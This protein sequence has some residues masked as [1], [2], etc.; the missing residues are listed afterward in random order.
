M[1]DEKQTCEGATTMTTTY[2]SLYKT[3]WVEVMKRVSDEDGTYIYIQE[4][5]LINGQAVSVLPFKVLNGQKFYLLRCEQAETLF[6]GTVKGGCDKEGESP[7][8]CAIR[9]L[10]EEAGYIAQP[11]DMISLGTARPSKLN[12]TTMHVFAVDVTN[13][14]FEAPEGDGTLNEATAYC[15]WVDLSEATQAMDPMIHVSILRLMSEVD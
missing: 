6:T 7:L 4:P 15:K 5:W 11:E 10:Y 13:L 8:D 9:E 12:T 14:P 2:E 3:K 1:D